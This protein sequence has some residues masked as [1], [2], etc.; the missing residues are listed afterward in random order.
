MK[1]KLL[2]FTAALL[3]EAGARGLKRLRTTRGGRADL[4]AVMEGARRQ[5][6]EADERGNILTRGDVMGGVPEMTVPTSRSPTFPTAPTRDGPPTH[7][8]SE[9]PA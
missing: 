1:D 7:F 5:G 3:A 6:A 8:E 9:V 4:A 2:I